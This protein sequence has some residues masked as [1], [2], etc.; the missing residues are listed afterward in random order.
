MTTRA[1]KETM[2]ASSEVDKLAIAVEESARA[3]N[4]SNP[5]FVEPARGTLDRAKARRHHIVFGRRGAGK[6]S[7]LAKGAADLTTD[8]RPIAFVNLETFKGLSYPDVLLS[9]LIKSLGEFKK[10]FETAATAPASK[11][12]F[13]TGLFGS[14]PR[15]P[16]L[17]KRTV[18]KLIN[19]IDKQIRELQPEL[20]SADSAH[21]TQ[22]VEHGQEDSAA[23]EGG[24]KT[25][26]GPVSVGIKGTLGAKDHYRSQ[27]TE[28]SRRL[29]VEFLH[30][31]VIDYQNLFAQVA[32]C[33]K[34]D[35]YLFLDD[36]Y[37]I[38][39]SDQPDVVDYFHRIAK[40]NRLWL[41][42][43]TI[44]HRTEWYRHSDPPVGLKLGDDADEIDLDLT[45]EN[46]RL[47]KDFLTHV[48]D[49]IA[50]GVGFRRVEDVLAP[51]AVDRLVLASGGVA[52]DFLA[53]FR[54]SIDVA[55]ER[56]GGSRGPRIGVEDVNQAA[57]KCDAAKRDE[58]KR[59]TPEERG[60]VEGAFEAVKTF[61]LEGANTNCFVMRKDRT[62]IGAGLIHELV[63]L[64]LLH[65]VQSRVTVSGRKGQLFVAYMLD[66]GQYTGERKRRGLEMIPFWQRKGTERLRRASLIY[67]P[68][69]PRAP[70][71]PN[72]G[73]PSPGV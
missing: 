68:W 53:L 15:R 10:W 62:D 59:D 72:G 34:G 8:R 21:V 46:Y 60:S 65:L 54:R 69:T 41:K 17:D 16:P 22:T 71:G 49:G 7:L 66:L 67:E 5:R 24:A 30:R 44:R 36:L 14:Q 56:G 29:K 9:V 48:L 32:D 11:T 50:S 47:T 63:D 38:R 51:A 26:I 57:G 31:H 12:T 37:H 43:G 55:R 20:H 40:G 28:E 61:C 27:V 4:V 1:Q 73:T 45:L 19:Q 2:L 64:R 6:T 13:W 23:L 25:A 58:L 52:R 18:N 33:S 35:A 42:I 3:A 70:V 39:K